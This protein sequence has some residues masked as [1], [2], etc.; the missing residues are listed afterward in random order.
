M[1]AE[2][3]YKN[4]FSFRDEILHSVEEVMKKLPKKIQTEYW[5]KSN[6]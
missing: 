6:K 5:K 3:K 2:I 4:L 1:I